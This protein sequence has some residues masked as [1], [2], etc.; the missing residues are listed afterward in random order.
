MGVWHTPLVDQTVAPVCVRPRLRRPVF[1]ELSGAPIAGKISGGSLPLANFVAAS[2]NNSVHAWHLMGLQ[3]L[4]GV[5]PSNSSPTSHYRHPRAWVGPDCGSRT[6]R[7]LLFSS[8]NNFHVL[9]LPGA[10]ASPSNGGRAL[11]NSP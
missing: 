6:E 7:G 1:G 11:D 3:L 9:S 5:L 2:T 8:V 10:T 4:L